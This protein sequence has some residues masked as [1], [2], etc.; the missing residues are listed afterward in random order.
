MAYRNRPYDMDIQLCSYIF[1]AVALAREDQHPC[2]SLFEGQTP[3]PK[4]LPHT[5]AKSQQGGDSLPHNNRLKNAYHTGLDTLIVQAQPLPVDRNIV[6]NSAK[7]QT[8]TNLLVYGL[9]ALLY[10]VCSL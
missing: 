3:R 7:H 2:E 9:R 5:P 6:E 4:A 8:Q 1:D 10:R